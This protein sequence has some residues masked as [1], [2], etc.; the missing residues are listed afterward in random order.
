MIILYIHLK[1]KDSFS[2]RRSQG[3]CCISSIFL[4]IIHTGIL[5]IPNSSSFHDVSDHKLLNCLILRHTA[6]TVGAAYRLY[7]A[8]PL[9]AAAV[10]APFLRLQER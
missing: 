9:L 5:D 6:G 4:T 10:V 8:A 3:K 7:V 1:E 2:P